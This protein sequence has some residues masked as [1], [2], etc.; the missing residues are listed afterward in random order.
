MYVT[1]FSFSRCGT[2]LKREKKRV[3]KK[4]KGKQAYILVVEW[5]FVYGETVLADRQ[6]LANHSRP[7]L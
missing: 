6:L 7:R 2:Q 4:A 1:D 3:A 5:T